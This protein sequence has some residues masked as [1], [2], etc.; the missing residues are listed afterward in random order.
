MLFNVI[1][2]QHVTRMT[3]LSYNSRKLCDNR[4][5]GK[6]NETWITEE[7]QNEA[8]RNKFMRLQRICFC[9]PQVDPQLKCITLSKYCTCELLYKWIGK[10]QAI[11]TGSEPEPTEQAPLQYG[12][13]FGTKNYTLRIS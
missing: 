1:A 7:K 3:I 9:R 4:Y 10:S 6:L 11:K 2:Y 8:P 12:P 13:T 5:Q